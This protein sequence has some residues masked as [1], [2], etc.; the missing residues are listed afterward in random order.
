MQKRTVNRQSEET[1]AKKEMD[2]KKIVKRQEM[3]E[4]ERETKDGSRQ[5]ERKGRM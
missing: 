1:D 3:A 4:G 5:E 2:R